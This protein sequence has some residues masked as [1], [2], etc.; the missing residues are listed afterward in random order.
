MMETVWFS[1]C[2]KTGQTYNSLILIRICKYLNI[3][4]NLLLFRF[5]YSIFCNFS[6]GSFSRRI[7]LFYFFNT[8][9][10]LLTASLSSFFRSPRV[11]KDTNWNNWYYRCWIGLAILYLLL[12]LFLLELRMTF[13]NNKFLIAFSKQQAQVTSFYTFWFFTPFSLS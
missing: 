7:G 9:N 8:F 5:L 4:T 10:V 6:F 3:S 13:T 11:K 1:T 2:E 12:L